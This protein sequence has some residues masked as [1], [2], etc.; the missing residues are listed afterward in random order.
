[1][2]TTSRTKGE[3]QRWKWFWDVTLKNQKIDKEMQ[4]LYQTYED[5]FFNEKF[6][7]IR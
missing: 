5:K 1:M 7:S 4:Y 6:T 3:R 2:P